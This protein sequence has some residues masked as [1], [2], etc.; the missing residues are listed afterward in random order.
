MYVNA[1]IELPLQ[2]G[3]ILRPKNVQ[4]NTIP[5]L[6]QRESEND[7]SKINLIVI[8]WVRTDRLVPY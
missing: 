5:D 1:F 3:F 4:T 7:Y 2:N 8:I 6:S